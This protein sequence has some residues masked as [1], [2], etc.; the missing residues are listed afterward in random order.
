ML[1][2]GLKDAKA[3]CLSESFVFLALFSDEVT[4]FEKDKCRKAMLHATQKDFSDLDA[5]DG[6][7]G[8]TCQYYK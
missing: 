6:K 5:E 3:S 2:Y 1:I 7:I 8:N 4:D